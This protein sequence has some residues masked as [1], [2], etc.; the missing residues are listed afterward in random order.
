MLH[1]DHTSTSSADATAVGST[2][3]GVECSSEAHHFIC[4]G[5]FCEQIQTQ[6]HPIHQA[7]FMERRGK[8][9]CI[10]CF[11]TYSDATIAAHIPLN[12]YVT[13]QQHLQQHTQD[14]HS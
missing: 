3:G 12:V 1:Q 8:I 14:Y 11:S 9:V 5:C 10:F 7:A 6:I 13:Y 4:K 2:T